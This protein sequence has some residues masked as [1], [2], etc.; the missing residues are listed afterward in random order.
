MIDDPEP[1]IRRLVDRAHRPAVAVG[2]P[3]FL[4]VDVA[5]DAEASVPPP[6]IDGG[7]PPAA[8]PP[9]ATNSLERAAPATSTAGHGRTRPVEASAVGTPASAPPDQAPPPAPTPPILGTVPAAIGLNTPTTS[10]TVAAVEATVEAAARTLGPAI[11]APNVTLRTTASAPVPTSRFVVGSDGVTGA[12]APTT[13]QTEPA[14]QAHRSDPPPSMAS[15][16]PRPA[17][18]PHAD[19]ADVASPSAPPAVPHVT[20]ERIEVVTPPTPTAA[21]DPFSSLATRRQGTHRNASRV[22]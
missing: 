8:R 18:G 15:A 14:L 2:R 22:S 17:V 1:V 20:I 10:P 6:S 11:T 19:L 9:A 12:R 16:P 4:A 5:V 21:A 13:A 3:A 7:V